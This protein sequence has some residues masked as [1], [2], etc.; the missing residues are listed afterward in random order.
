MKKLMI[1]FILLCVATACG[2][3]TQ[4][5]ETDPAQDQLSDQPD[6][7]EDQEEINA[8][9]GVPPV[10]YYHGKHY[11]NMGGLDELPEQF[12]DSGDK[13]LGIESD[14]NTLPNQECYGSG[15]VGIDT[16]GNTIYIDP[17]HQD[18]I[19]IK[20]QS[21]YGLFVYNPSVDKNYLDIVLHNK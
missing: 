10:I 11:S 1:I 7:T 4:P 16:I 18:F 13:I 9:H 5:K 20:G 3:N 12:I 15:F 19:M 17:N 21:R 14:D 6:E 2:N 8:P